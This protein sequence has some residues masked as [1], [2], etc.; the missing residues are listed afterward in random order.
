MHIHTSVRAQTHTLTHAEINEQKQ[1]S[2][3]ND[4]RQ[5]QQQGLL[6]K[7]ERTKER[8]RRGY[9]RFE[10]QALSSLEICLRPRLMC[11]FSGLTHEHK[12]TYRK[13]HAEQ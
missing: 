1:E 5:R 11:V 7:K 10:T 13:T 3:Q 8:K 9:E 2:W 4:L 12:H 6:Q